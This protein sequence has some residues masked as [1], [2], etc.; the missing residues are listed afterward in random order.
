MSLTRLSVHPS[1]RR[2]SKS[3]RASV[4]RGV[5]RG[6]GRR[7]HWRCLRS[8]AAMV[9]W[10]GH[11]RANSQ[12]ETARIYEK[13]QQ[14]KING[15][16]CSS[17]RRQRRQQTSYWSRHA[18]SRFR[19]DKFEPRGTWTIALINKIKG[20]QLSGLS[21]PLIH[22]LFMIIS[23]IINTFTSCISGKIRVV[24]INLCWCSPLTTTFDMMS[25]ISCALIQDEKQRYHDSASWLIKFFP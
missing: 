19:P 7:L 2:P 22:L 12:R 1:R 8:A 17:R 11:R 18:L 3:C 10:Q 16:S 4:G 13:Q 14:W 23:C 6:S 5:G 20:E 25:D 15:G 9:E 24:R 21:Y